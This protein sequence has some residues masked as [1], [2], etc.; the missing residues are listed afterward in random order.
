MAS[1]DLSPNSGH[2]SRTD[3]ALNWLLGHNPVRRTSI[4]LGFIVVV[5]WAILFTSYFTLSGWSSVLV[6]T[7]ETGLVGAI[8]VVGIAFVAFV[9]FDQR[10][11]KR[12]RDVQK[13]RNVRGLVFLSVLILLGLFGAFIAAFAQL[14]E[15]VSFNDPTAF[16]AHWLTPRVAM[17]YTISLLSTSG[18]NIDP[19]SVMATWLVSLQMIADMSLV[20]VV[21]AVTINRITNREGS[22]VQDSR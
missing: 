20:L 13:D 17:Y 16:S 1:T 12:L 21:A 8:A 4:L 19:K 11:W 7:V 6:N 15:Y 2:P 10:A 18:S 22:E 9:T 14:Y 3:C 5:P